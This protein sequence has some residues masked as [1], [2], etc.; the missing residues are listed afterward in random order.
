MKAPV[1][2]LPTI[3]ALLLAL[4]GPP[5]LSIVS[6]RVLGDST[7]V[8]RMLPF[9]LILW[10]MLALVLAVV[11]YVER[12]PLASIGLKQPRGT[13]IIWA[14]LLVLSINF[15][16]AP[17]LMWIVNKAGLSGYERGLTRLSEL[18]L[19]YRVFLAISAGVIEEIFYRGY[20]VERLASLTGSYWLGGLIAVVAFG[21]AHF[22]GWG[23]GP[24]LVFLFDGAAA[25]LFYVWKR[26]LL[27]LII[28]HVIGDT[29][30]LVVL[31]PLSL[32]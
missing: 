16:L 15:I 1:I 25:T 27:A 19:W 5:L 20:A 13:T 28:A 17:A 23:F 7:S 32:S 24:A 22:P 26:D 11:I 29:I 21:L 14:V 10:A 9:D 6:Q 30:G 4:C 3:A 31:P 12:Q 2:G 8:T 18:P